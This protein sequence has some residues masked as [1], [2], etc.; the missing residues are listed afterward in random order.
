MIVR[1]FSRDCVYLDHRSLG[2]C[3]D[4]VADSCGLVGFEIFCV[5]GVHR[6]EIGYVVQQHGCL[7]NVV[8]TESGFF[9]NV[10]EVVEGTAGLCFYAFGNFSSGRICGQLP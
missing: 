10:A 8:E 7:D 5:D 9:K 1:L 2:K 4:L 6:T 3:G